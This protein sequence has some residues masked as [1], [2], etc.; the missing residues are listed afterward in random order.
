MNPAARENLAR[1]HHT[2]KGTQAEERGGGE[3]LREVASAVVDR[4][5]RAETA[6]GKATSMKDNGLINDHLHKAI[7]KVLQ[8]DEQLKQFEELIDARLSD[9]ATEAA[10]NLALILHKVD[11]KAVSKAFH[12]YRD[13]Q[14]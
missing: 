11:S 2:L 4:A 13:P 3:S 9:E 5:A 1:T 12:L 7:I 8:N 6:I 14:M 10:I